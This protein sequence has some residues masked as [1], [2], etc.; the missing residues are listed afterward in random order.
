MTLNELKKGDIARITSIDS[1]DDLRRKLLNW[2][3]GLNSDVQ[4][5][6]KAPAKHL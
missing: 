4:F 1:D 6:R 2:G 3:I 5:L